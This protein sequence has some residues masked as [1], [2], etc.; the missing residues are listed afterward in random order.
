MAFWVSLGFLI[1]AV[2]TFAYTVSTAQ[3]PTIFWA[4]FAVNYLYYL[5]ITQ[6]GIIFSTV[7]R[8]ARSGWGS[9]YG[10][11]GEVLTLS[12]IPFAFIGFLILYFGGAE[13]LFWWLHPAPA[14]AH[15]AEHAHISPWLNKK[16]HFWRVL[17]S[18]A[19]FYLMS[20]IY[21]RSTRVEE[22]HGG[23]GAHGGHAEGHGGGDLKK[24]LNILAGIVMF[25]FV[26]ENSILA[27]DFG[28]TIIPHWE[29]SIFAPYYWAGNLLAGTAFLFIM[30]VFFIPRAPG[31]EIAKRHLDSIG[32]VFI[33]F[34]LL[35][36]Y[37][38]WSQHIVLWYGDLPNLVGPHMK[39][40][41]GEFGG[42]FALM[43]FTLFIIPFLMLL[44]RRFKL[45]VH[46]LTVAA[47]LI[48]M[49][50][51]INRYLMIIPEFSKDGSPVFL[52]WPG[53]SLI[54]GGLSSTLLSFFVFRKLFP[55]VAL[56]TGSG[57]GAH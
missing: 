21:F 15:G 54:I 51:W 24:R 2:I 42:T 31:E 14:G 34:I 45:C 4:Q 1:N 52:T 35:W 6:T 17:L 32:K 49:G 13:H 33:G 38:Y 50:V 11:L 23:E 55:G 16:L 30:A 7:M 46:I 20:Y 8:A 41:T 19:F 26:V 47:F 48:G 28:M 3:D 53:I 43:L 18:M 40:M 57:E 56:K 37:M 9:R 36:V 25:S 27:W 5:G 44:F 22:E 12:Y 29:S 10:R 39:R